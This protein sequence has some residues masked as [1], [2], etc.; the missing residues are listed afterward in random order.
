MPSYV[1]I[2]LLLIILLGLA[3]LFILCSNSKYKFLGKIHRERTAGSLIC[4]G[5]LIWAGLQGYELLG[6]DFPMIAS[7]IPILVPLLIVGVYFLMDYIFTRAVGGLMIMLICEVFYI[8]QE[9]DMPA[10]FLFS[11]CGYLF[12][13]CGM[14]MIG[15]PWR[16][17]DILFKSIE[18]KKFGKKAGG[19]I[20]TVT[21]VMFIPFVFMYV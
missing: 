21:L 11:I 3:A 14:Y 9:N 17:R 19:I 5:A 16:F 15:Q 20:T 7:I 2:A 1:A 10:R 6:Q 4:A 13:V 8:S 12:A 18:D